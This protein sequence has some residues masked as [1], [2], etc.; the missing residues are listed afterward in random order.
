MDTDVL[1][2]LGRLGWSR[3]DDGVWRFVNADGVF[4]AFADPPA[5][6]R[7]PPPGIDAQQAT[8]P[9]NTFVSPQGLLEVA[10]ESL[11]DFA[12][13]AELYGPLAI[14]DAAAAA[15][16]GDETAMRDW[17]SIVLA[18]ALDPRLEQQHAAR[19]QRDYKAVARL[20]DWAHCEQCRW[21]HQ[22]GECVTRFHALLREPGWANNGGAWQLGADDHSVQVFA[23]AAQNTPPCLIV[24]PPAVGRPDSSDPWSPFAAAAPLSDDRR[25]DVRFVPLADSGRMWCMRC[26]RPRPMQPDASWPCPICN[27]TATNRSF[28]PELLAVCAYTH[29]QASL[30]AAA[31]DYSP[32][33]RAITQPEHHPIY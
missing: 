4:V 13:R 8:I 24:V 26:G 33:L 25:F 1:A 22:P 19:A 9:I 14:A 20:L 3:L 2:A 21:R 10:T 27:S 16:S 23:S 5:V 18:T 29:D 31:L 15:W 17:A 28:D 11:V 32:Y 12:R 6:V 30:V 7:L